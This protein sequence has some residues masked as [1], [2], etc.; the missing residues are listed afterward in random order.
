MFNVGVL[1]VDES[2]APGWWRKEGGEGGVD[3]VDEIKF[4]DLDD[5]AQEGVQTT[6]QVGQEPSMPA[7]VEDSS[8]DKNGGGDDNEEEDDD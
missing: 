6:A 5:F 2:V 8:D 3:E 7:L 4:L 1:D